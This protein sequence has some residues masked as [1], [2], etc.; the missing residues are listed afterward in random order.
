M[1]NE[2][3][4]VFRKLTNKED[5]GEEE[6]YGVVNQIVEDNLSES[7]IA[8]FL[9]SLTTKEP[10]TAEITGI[11][12]GMRDNCNH[13]DPNVEA[14][15]IDTCG[16]GGGYSTFNVSTSV[17]ILASAA[18]IPVAKHGS[19]SISS[20]SG[21]AD[22]LEELGVEINL[23]PSQTE[24]LLERA[25]ITFLFAPNFHPIMK[26]VLPIENQLMVKTIFYSVIG[27]LINPADAR[28]HLLG[29]YKP[30]LVEKVG[31]I[32]KGLN[33][34]HAL[35]VHGM[36]GLD[37]MSPVGETRVAEVSGDE[38]TE[39][40]LKPE[41]FGIKPCSLSDLEGGSPS[42]NAEILRKIYRGDLN[43]PKKDMVLLNGAGAL[44]VGGRVS[45]LKEGVEEAERIIDEGRA[46]DKLKEL[47]L[48]SREVA[49]NNEAFESP[50]KI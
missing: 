14:N 15:L 40:K 3:K 7:Q 50:Q 39:Y 23:K 49:D 45:S 18:G 27:P 17:S 37:E 33:F 42:K 47:I 20:S 29:V 46:M 11:A 41:E 8:G 31:K 12:R 24:K 4:S 22:V 26:K 16:T 38:L 1:S 25:G 48:E 43:G 5:L 6:A 36:D 10:T 21:S 44:Y 30:E 32:L 28:R 19:R 13:I 35:V 2:L 34:E 9:A